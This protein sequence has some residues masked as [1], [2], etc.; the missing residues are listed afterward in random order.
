MN[1]ILSCL[2]ALLLLVAVPA[3][4]TTWL[5]PSAVGTLAAALDSAVAGDS[6]VV[7]A[8]TYLEY[9]LVLESGVTVRGETGDPADVTIDAQALGRIFAGVGLT[10]GRL[11]AL[12]LTNGDAP[13]APVS[14][15]TGGAIHLK[16]SSGFTIANCV[17]TGN[18][19]KFGGAITCDG[20]SVTIDGCEFDG[21]HAFGESWVTG[22]A[23]LIE[24]AAPLIRGSTFT[25]NTAVIDSAL[26]DGGAIFAR[27]SSSVVED[28]VFTGNTAGAGAGACYSWD[29]DVTRY[30]RCTFDLNA[31]DAGGA[32]Y[33][34]TSYARIFD[35]DFT[36]NTAENGGAVFM[37]QGS[38]PRIR[39]SRFTDNVATP[40]SG[41][42]VDAWAST[43]EFD[44]CTFTGNQAALRGGALS[45]NGTSDADVRNCAFL[46]NDAVSAAGAVRLAWTAVV[47][48]E[49][50]TIL[51][52]G[53]GGFRV[54][55]SATLLV[56]RSI[57]AFGTS[58]KA[59]V[60]SESG[61]AALVDTNVHAN[62]GGNW[63]DCIAEQ[64][65]ANGNVS[66]DPMFCDRSTG[67]WR[68]T[69]PDSP[70]LP[71]NS[72][73]GVLIGRFS[74][75]CGCPPDSIAD[76]F[77]PGEY[78]TIG[79]ALA[80]S[81]AGDAVGV[82][83]GT[84]AEAVTLKEGVDVVGAAANLCRVEWP[85]AGAEPAL[86]WANG[87]VDPTVVSDLTFDGLGGIAQVVLAESTTTG[88]H[89]QRN[90][91]T[92]GATDGIV[93]G[94]DSFLRVGGALEYSNDIWGNGGASPRNVRNLNVVA[95]SL[96][97]LLNFWGTQRYDSIL[98]AIEGKVLSCPITNAGHTESLCAPLTALS[99][100]AIELGG[101]LGLAA[102]P[103]PF[104][105]GCRIALSI[106]KPGLVRLEVFDVRG[107][108]VAALHQGLLP[109]GTHAVAW[110]GRDASGGPVAPGIYFV[111]VEAG[112]RALSRKI[113][114]LR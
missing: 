111:R 38:G 21:N 58:G 47:R 106:R 53:G 40:H 90:V 30:E 45:F 80:A 15:D 85:G 79:A 92:G 28:C 86:L 71:E 23:I 12:T 100:P 78:P 74:A 27:A 44:D 84:Y 1:R 52:S 102:W 112:S 72:P 26:G 54:E 107:R 103:N 69:L 89:L 114:H 9:D 55:D 76:V 81:S 36:G 60:C 87:I 8:G 64:L 49:S 4:A 33:L 73:G 11:E 25:G 101:G 113:V 17:F 56:D 50:C 97:A 18:T 99:S 65:A 77:V 19:A 37:D 6:V 105:G 34:E 43:P 75:G 13:A 46:G 29:G 14:D 31:A 82:C 62:A 39:D 59:V 32:L 70:C 20:S 68:L 24:G 3:A 108:R 104:R 95:D 5:V 42:A 61:V 48:V 57:I 35:C 16:S 10:A 66:A 88:L 110:D 67:D 94:P 41:G 7:A 2:P 93:N 22:G 51:E 91:I 98:A 109:A 63:T 83:S 96:D